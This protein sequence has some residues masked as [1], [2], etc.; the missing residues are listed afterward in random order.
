MKVK[1]LDVKSALSGYLKYGCISVR[2]AAT[3]FIK[4][5]PLFKQLVWREFYMHILNDYP[6]TLTNP[7]K[8]KYSAIQWSQSKKKLESWKNGITGYPIVDAGMR[9]LN[10][11][12]YMHNRARLI[13]ACFLIKTLQHLLRC[14]C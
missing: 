13:T 8:E 12:G 4:I 2:E 7:L 9:Q 5:E 11:T 1:V 14:R 10:T 3:E 6:E